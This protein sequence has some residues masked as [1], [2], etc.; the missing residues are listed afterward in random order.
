MSS[1]E[2]LR[3]VIANSSSPSQDSTE[4]RVRKVRVIYQDPYATDTDSSDDKKSKCFVREFCVPP[5]G[6]SLSQSTVEQQLQESSSEDSNSNDDSGKNP[7]RR[8]NVLATTPSSS[9]GPK[10]PVGVRLRKW[11][12]WAA[13][14]RNPHTRSRVWLGTFASLEE[15]AQAYEDKKREYDASFPSEDQQKSVNN[16]V[17][18]SSSAAGTAVSPSTSKSHPPCCSTNGNDSESLVSSH[19]SPASVLE[20]DNCAVSALNCDFSKEECFDIVE[21][22]VEDLEIPDLSFIDEALGS[23]CPVVDQDLDLGVDFTSLIDEFGRMYDDY[24]GIGDELDFLG[25]DFEGGEMLPTELPDYDF[26]FDSEEFAYLDD[27]QQQ[28]QQQQQQQP[29]N[30]ACL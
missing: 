13:E 29:L 20:V 5:S 27:H 30:I 7:I 25:F 15:A 16:M 4:S 19:T 12:K 8:R 28:Q 14:I 11:G 9:K 6:L 1:P 2:P 26:E 3:R 22:E 24:C 23:A 18:Q 10:K 17:P 21:E